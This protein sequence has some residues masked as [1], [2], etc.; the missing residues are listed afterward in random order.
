MVG[1]IAQRSA[2]REE[3]KILKF[4]AIS[5]AGANNHKCHTIWDRRNSACLLRNR[6][7]GASSRDLF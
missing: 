3:L 6:T 1:N 5:F 2:V 4:L 7:L